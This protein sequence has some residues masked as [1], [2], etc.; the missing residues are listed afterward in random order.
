MF[1]QIYKNGQPVDGGSYPSLEEAAAALE[2]AQ[3]GGEVTEVD[4][5]DKIVRRYTLQECRAAAQRFRRET[6]V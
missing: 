4:R 6:A 1:F 2:R 3:Q 5:S